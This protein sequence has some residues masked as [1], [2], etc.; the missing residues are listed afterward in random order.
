VTPRALRSLLRSY[1]VH[2]TVWT[3][4]GLF[5][6]TQ[7]LMQGLLAGSPYPW[8]HYLITWLTGVWL[9]ALLT[10]GVFW[11]AHRFPFRREKWL[12]RAGLHL[13]FSL[14]FSLLQISMHSLIIPAAGVFPQVMPTVPA[15]FLALTVLGLHSTLITYWALLGIR[16]A[17]DY[18][19]RYQEQQREA[20]RLQLHSS[21]LRAQLVSAHLSTLKTQLQPHFVFNTLN[22]IMVLV[23]KQQTRE[24]EQM[25]ALLSDLL[26]SVLEDVE[27]QEVPLARE[28][29]YLQLYLSIEQIRFADRLEVNINPAPDVL[30]A[31]F[32]HMGLQ[33]I[34]ENAI[35][36]G[37]GRS[38]DAGRI[39]IQ[40]YRQGGSLFVIVQDDGPGLQSETVTGRG[41]GLSNTRARLAQLYGDAGELRVENG[42]RGTI[43][44]MHLPFRAARATTEAE[45]MEVHAS[46]NAAG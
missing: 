38:S 43:V 42:N 21:E 19:H 3:I 22:A 12:R 18:Y 17:I 33:P 40:A 28:L 7:G 39:D 5:F 29:E 14:S 37:I 13:L 34:V 11:L 41:I 9:S 27:A 30:D 6:F 25:L 1:I 32:P 45:I 35:R 46:D 15:T 4:L 16:Y 24:A 31:A 36:H 44:T 20:L 23:R 2:F 26:R 10:P 8:W